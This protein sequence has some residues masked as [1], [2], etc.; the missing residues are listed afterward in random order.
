[1]TVH[2]AQTLEKLEQIVDRLRQSGMPDVVYQ[3]TEG[4][5]TGE[6]TELEERLQ[7]P[8]PASLSELIKRCGSLNLLWCLP[9]HCI[10][11]DGPECSYK[12]SN[13]LEQEQCI[14]D[15][16]TGE[17]GWNHEYIGYFT[18]YGE[19]TD[20]AADE[21]RYL[22]LNY[23][24]AGDPILLDMATSTTEPAVFCYHHELDQFTL[25]AENLPA[26][27]DTMLTLHGLWLW[28]WF[29]VADEHGIQLNSPS[30]QLW[31]RWLNMFC[32]MKLENAQSLETLI[33]YTTMH[34]VDHPAVLQAFQAYDPKDIFLAWEQHWQNI[35]HSQVS[36][37][38]WAVLV[39]ETA[40]IGAADWVRSLWEPETA[41]AWTSS[42]AQNNTLHAKGA[43][44]STRAY[45]SARCLPEQEG[46]VCVCN[47]LLQHSG[48]EDKLEGYTANGQLQHFRSPQV[49]NW[50]RDKVNHPVDGWAILFAHS[51]STAE[52][53]IEWLSDSELHQKIAA[54]ALDIMIHRDLLPALEA[55]AWANIS[56]LLLASLQLVMLKK[57]KRRIEAVL[58]QLS[59]LELL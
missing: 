13:D 8:L 27:I 9:Q 25:L 20:S 56:D 5:S 50:M 46:L 16:I 1:M 51:R 22:I 17:F 23:N 44:A 40:G 6:L 28:D 32:T 21:Q 48:A 2:F 24:G 43:F 47:H 49:I 26:Y 19:D 42:L 30:L 39:G 54:E 10:V 58:K 31:Q 3:W 53:L 57:D 37:S 4:I 38:T 41:Q 45:L 35:Q 14:L 55:D 59:D 12:N 52:Q 34:G 33:H 18:S 36:F 15:D 7:M 29:K 11:A